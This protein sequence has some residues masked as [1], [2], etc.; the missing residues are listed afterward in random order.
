MRPRRPWRVPSRALTLPIAT[1]VLAACSATTT[2]SP[3]ATAEPTEIPTPTAS[4]TA[5]PD[6]TL[7]PTPSPTPLNEALL[8]ERL[9]VLVV[10]EDSDRFREAV[11][12]VTNTD[13]IMVVSV[14]ADQSQIVMLSLPRDTVDVPMPDGSIYRG[15][16]NS[17][18]HHHG[19]DG[20]R[21]AVST[22][23]E[24]EID[25]YLKID[26]DDLVRM[27]NTVGGIDVEVRT[28]I[29]DAHTGLYLDVGPAHLDG[30]QALY[31]SRIRTDGDYA[32]AARQQDVVMAMVRKYVDPDTPWT[33][34]GLLFH[35]GAFETSLDL[36]D[37]PTLVEIGRRAA[38]AEVTGAVLAPPRFSLFV[39]EEPGTG[40]GWVMIP[41]VPE[42]QAYAGS[43]IGE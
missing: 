24:V 38:D 8:D 3:P 26:M 9:T 39:G 16:I 25:A 7:E 6:P 32:R 10:G 13:A 15:K 1:L 20:L 18:A 41:N 40:R 12:Y 30:S 21:G 14:S 42:M 35:L 36:A 22:L 17:I 23:L 37:L 5:R 2:P 31:Y 4:P 11:G 43:L 34:P 27:V 29:A 28:P 33:L 19:L